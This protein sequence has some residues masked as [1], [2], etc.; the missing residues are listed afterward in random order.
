MQEN[1]HHKLLV[2]EPDKQYTCSIHIHNEMKAKMSEA[3][4]RAVYE[5]LRDDVWKV[6]GKNTLD[7]AMSHNC[8]E[9]MTKEISKAQAIRILTYR[10]MRTYNVI[11][12]MMAGDAENDKIALKHVSRL[13]EI[14]G[15]RSHVFL[16][17]NAQTAVE[18]GQLEK[19]KSENKNASPNR[20]I[21]S[22]LRLFKGI[23]NLIREELKNN[24]LVGTG[25]EIWRT[26]DDMGVTLK[27]EIF[28]GNNMRK[29]TAACLVERNVGKIAENH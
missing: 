29:F 7:I 3:Q 1:E 17:A 26:K 13:A 28:Q 23:T 22:H 6:Y 19:W 15:V 2:D 25:P 5:S 10:Y 16:P 20:I 12:L 9:I 21:K 11:G 18:S 27:N 8:M 24:T 4:Q 14:P